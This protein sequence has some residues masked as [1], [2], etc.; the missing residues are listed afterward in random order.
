MYMLKHP[1]TQR[2]IERPV[3]VVE[4]GHVPGPDL[5]RQAGGAETASSLGH[6]DVAGVNAHDP[7]VRPD[8]RGQSP[9]HVTGA[10]AHI[11]RP[12]PSADAGH[13]DGAGTEPLD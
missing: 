2:S 5:E 7:P 6:H 11:D 10:T 8:H 13:L 9:S 1:L 3:R 4:R 12:K